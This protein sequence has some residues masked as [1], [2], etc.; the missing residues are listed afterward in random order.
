MSNGTN[1]TPAEVAA[2]IDHT[3]LKADATEAEVLQICR[4]AKQY[5]FATV[6]VNAGWVAAA[7]EEL[8]GSGV[9]ITTVVG[10]P[11]G[12]TTT[13][14]KAAEAAFAIEDGATEVDMVLNIGLLKSGDL[15]GVQR[16]VAGVA[17]AV[18][19]QAVLKVILETGLL[20]DEEKV[21]AC[22]I[23]KKAGADFVKTS[24]GFG[25]G[26]ATVE[27]IALMRRTVGPDFGV[28]ASG[29]VRDRETALQM[30][31]AGATRIGASSG[32]AIVT[33]GGQGEGY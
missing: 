29:G 25:K 23:C 21:T 13:A 31:A 11:L 8:K 32:I 28:K 17:A 3:I 27:D 18:K 19:G 15:E 22:E 24:T 12:A 5:K 10:F 16:D 14:S 7:A 1:Y 2:M 20:T 4:E 33:G 26:G 30:F 9:G 6:C